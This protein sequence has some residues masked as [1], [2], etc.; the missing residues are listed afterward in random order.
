VTVFAVWQPMLPT[1][2]FAPV[3]GVLARLDDQRVR[4]YWDPD[5]LLAR[6]LAADAR[7]PQPTP[8]CCD[9]DGIPWDVAAVYGAE[10]TWSDLM[11]PARFLNGPIVAVAG[12]VAAAL[13]SSIER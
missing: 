5:H 9:D 12:D 11:P 1:D 7:Q 4:Q 8:E 10:S 6:R 13:K 3:A 2:W